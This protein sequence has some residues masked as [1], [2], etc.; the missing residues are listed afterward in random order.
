MFERFA[1]GVDTLKVRTMGTNTNSDRAAWFKGDD[2][3][4]KAQ[5]TTTGSVHRFV[6]LGAPGAGKGTQ[7][8]LLTERLGVCHLSTGDIFRNAKKASAKD[9]SPAMRRALNRM[10]AGELVTDEMVISLVAERT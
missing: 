10:R 8:E 7:A 1:Q 6:L 3:P 9:I 5:P 2:T 4:C